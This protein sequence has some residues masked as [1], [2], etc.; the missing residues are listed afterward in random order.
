MRF[1]IKNIDIREGSIFSKN[2]KIILQ[3]FFHNK[4]NHPGPEDLLFL[5]KIIQKDKNKIRA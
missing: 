4:K 3:N 5:E 1:G 2:D